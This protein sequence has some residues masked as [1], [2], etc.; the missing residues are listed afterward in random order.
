MVRPCEALEVAVDG[1]E[2]IVDKLQTA[3]IM[4]KYEKMLKPY[5]VEHSIESYTQSIAYRT[6][7]H[8]QR[9]DDKIVDEELQQGDLEPRMVAK[10]TWVVQEQDEKPLRERYLY[11]QIYGDRRRPDV[12]ISVHHDSDISKHKSPRESPAIGAWRGGSNMN[13]NSKDE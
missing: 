8:D 7:K 2:Y 1:T 10:D 12:R 13:D 4:R 9:L 5:S 11:K 3:V 6:K